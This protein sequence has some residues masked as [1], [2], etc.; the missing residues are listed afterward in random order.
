VATIASLD[1]LLRLR[2]AG[3][4]R[5]VVNAINHVQRLNATMERLAATQGASR[6]EVRQA[7]RETER[8]RRAEAKA[9]EK[10]IADEVAFR[11]F[12]VR[13]QRQVAAEEEASRRKALQQTRL[14]NRLN[15]Q[16]DHQAAQEKSRQDRLLMQN[17]RA[18][19]RGE[20]A[21][22]QAA[23][24]ASAERRSA[25]VGGA[26][27]FAGA[28]FGLG[29]R[30]ASSALRQFRM[31]FANTFTHVGPFSFRVGAGT[32]AVIGLG[33]ALISLGKNAVQTAADFE[34]TEVAFEVLTG[35]AERARAVL[36]GAYQFAA[37]TP[38]EIKDVLRAT[39]AL[40]AVGIE[41]ETALEMV[42]RLGNI[43]AAMPGEMAD[44]LQHVVRA[45]AQMHAKGTV[46]AEEM[47][48]QLANAGIPAWE[49]LAHRIGVTV[50]EAMARAKA[51]MVSARE[52]I[53]AILDLAASPRFA[54]MQERLMGTLIG[55]W[56]NFKDNVTFFLRDL[57][58]ALIEGFQIK[59]ATTSLTDFFLHL[60]SRIEDIKPAILLVGQ[61]ART[62]FEVIL[63]LG[64]Q[65]VDVFA[66][67]TRGLNAGPGALANLR[68]QVI[69]VMHTVVSKVT[70]VAFTIAEVI[71]KAVH[72]V[73]HLIHFV[74]RGLRHIVPPEGQEE[75]KE[76]ANN[77]VRAGWKVQQAIDAVAAAG[78]HAQALPSLEQV[79]GG[80]EEIGQRLLRLHAGGVPGRP[81]LD[82][83]ARALQGWFAV[84]KLTQPL[85][86][87]AHAFEIVREGA[88]K[89]NLPLGS[90]NQKV[91][92]LVKSS[93]GPLA[94]FKNELKEIADLAQFALPGAFKTSADAAAFAFGGAA[95]HAMQ[96]ARALKAIED[97]QVMAL[98]KR[99]KAMQSQRGGDPGALEAGSRE[100]VGLIN[101]AINA[102][103]GA[104][105]M[106]GVLDRLLEEDKQ[107][108]KEFN[109]FKRDFD[110][111]RKRLG[112]G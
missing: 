36:E 22:A 95:A 57:G 50:P 86:G 100:A 92:D 67:W 15:A 107:F 102:Q 74:A 6:P 53:M 16:L 49:A 64:R 27:R 42:K 80:I 98:F 91:A 84:V 14:N 71:L 56:S 39:Q 59:T 85:L 93:G 108:H 24:R 51:G 109:N 17:T 38:F 94:Q 87:L 75:L 7:I 11:A 29:L 40:T 41:A 70:S 8:A 34:R 35:S 54:G 45:L 78:G 3:F 88:T 72:S 76:F 52:G 104:V 112:L 33:S 2:S 18:L 4:R 23:R 105:D 97:A 79:A 65:L 32:A 5:E 106:K 99:A 77:I 66:D 25:L 9:R 43:S 103:G 96:S 89:I 12:T 62:V 73:L 1:I 81:G 28:P 19:I 69:G 30:A 63:A 26:G 58:K 47:T 90:L 110:E 61:V 44:N 46:Q 37:T 20:E 111:A 21:R 10:Q 55:L 13:M 82:V 101:K 48:R 60:R 31:D 83:N 68:S